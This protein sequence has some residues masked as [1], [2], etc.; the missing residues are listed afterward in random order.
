M[1]FLFK[2]KRKA[3]RSFS[4]L[5]VF[6]FKKLKKIQL[7]P[8]LL[9]IGMPYLRGNI[10]IKSGCLVS[11]RD[12][13]PLGISNIC[14]MSTSATGYIDIGNNFNCSGVT[15]YSSSRVA[16][17]DNVMIAPGVTIIDDDMHSVD[18]IQRRKRN[19]PSRTKPISIED[20]VWL[21]K[22]VTVLK[23]VTIGARS[24]IGA[25]VTI[26]KT[27]LPDSVVTHSIISL[28]SKSV[29]LKN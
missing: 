22:G 1:F 18:Y 16:I 4:P 25:D 2:A 17:G 10:T 29:R 8:N 6:L 9:I 15:I 28:T 3:F 23:G 11:L 5:L 24:V 12:G 20:D 21:G 14:R 7:G 13:N 26:S 19:A 27:I